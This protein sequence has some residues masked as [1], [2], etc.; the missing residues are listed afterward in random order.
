[1]NNNHRIL[2]NVM[3]VSGSDQNAA[4]KAESTYWRIN[5]ILRGFSQLPNIDIICDYYNSMNNELGAYI[6]NRF[7]DLTY[8]NTLF[9]PEENTANKI[10]N[11]IDDA[12]R[13]NIR[14]LLFSGQREDIEELNMSSTTHN[15]IIQFTNNASCFL[16]TEPHNIPPSF[17]QVCYTEHLALL[18]I[19][20]LLVDACMCHYLSVSDVASHHDDK[21][22]IS[23]EKILFLREMLK[24][25]HWGGL[26]DNAKALITHTVSQ[27]QD[28]T[29]YISFLSIFTIAPLD[30]DD[31]EIKIT[32]NILD[33]YCI[34]WKLFQKWYFRKHG[35]L[36]IRGNRIENPLDT[37]FDRNKYQGQI[38][39]SAII[40]EIEKNMNQP[41][42]SISNRPFGV[43]CRYAVIIIKHIPKY[44][45]HK[46]HMEA[47]F[48]DSIYPAKW[49]IKH[50]SEL[51]QYTPIL[52]Y[53]EIIPFM[54]DD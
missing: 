31:S 16:A 3:M 44:P 41:N 36:F 21:Q 18:Y 40:N 32:K 24:N 35:R 53:L 26:S 47:L 51:S 23:A 19:E 37:I 48:P 45:L 4:Q 15:M 43:D 30:L 46:A 20:A 2:I 42:L 1:M 38:S 12:E 39:G 29:P 49:A 9:N 13:K 27:L 54:I 33:D 34:L 6:R 52:S 22:R 17:Y 7:L 5:N 11:I 10:L 8:E 25:E 28:T 14:V 50:W